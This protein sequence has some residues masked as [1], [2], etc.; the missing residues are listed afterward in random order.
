MVSDRKGFICLTLFFIL[1]AIDQHHYLKLGFAKPTF[2]YKYEIL[3]DF[4]TGRALTL[5]KVEIPYPDAL[6]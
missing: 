1:L 5:T 3:P 2:R 4:L 6:M